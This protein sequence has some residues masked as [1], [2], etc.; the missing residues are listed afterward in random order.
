M[1][2]ISS[3]GWGSNAGRPPSALGHQGTSWAPA[4]ASGRSSREV[5]YRRGMCPFPSPSSR[6]SQLYF[7]AIYTAHN[8]MQCRTAV[9]AVQAV[10]DLPAR[11][12]TASPTTPSRRRRGV[13]ERRPMKLAACRKCRRRATATAR[14]AR[15]PTCTGR[16][17]FGRG[18]RPGALQHSPAA[19][20]RPGQ[21]AGSAGRHEGPR[22][23]VRQPS[24]LGRCWP[25]RA[26]PRRGPARLT[27]RP[28]NIFRPQS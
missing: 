9:Q 19:S 4:S 7:P 27:A 20:R 8:A 15:T 5:H 23:S 16:Q 11:R 13:A 24:S 2:E 22:L 12:S 6:A 17:G 18:L 26:D 25:D 3:A 21:R 14:T 28:G 10:P 1:M